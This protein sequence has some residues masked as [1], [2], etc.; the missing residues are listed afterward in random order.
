MIDELPELANWRAPL[1]ELTRQLRQ[2]DADRDPLLWAAA[3]SIESASFL[4]EAYEQRGLDP[5]E[6]YR[7]ALLAAVGSARAAVGA[8]TYAAQSRRVDAARKSS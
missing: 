6:A 7:A 2:P 3:C 8:A 4:L 1:A 5:G